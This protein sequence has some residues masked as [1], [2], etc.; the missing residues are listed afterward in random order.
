[1]KEVNYTFIGFGVGILLLLGLY[2]FW[3]IPEV[4]KSYKRGLEQC[5]K[6]IDTIYIPGKDSI[7]YRD[8]TI[9]IEKPVLV[10]ESDTTL[11]LKTKNQ[12]TFI[13]GKDTIITNPEVKLTVQKKDGKWET[14]NISA[15][16]VENIQ[17]KDFVKNLDT[18]KIKI[19]EYIPI[20][21]KE[22]NWLISGI[23]YIA[24]ILTTVITILVA[25]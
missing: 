3:H 10:S 17:H 14:E 9:Y 21:E 13:S 12:S 25:K 2:F 15:D 1:M 8:T 4:D 6:E 7:E 19:P 5:T 16:W 24:G 20:V 18:I 22:T 11:I 23:T